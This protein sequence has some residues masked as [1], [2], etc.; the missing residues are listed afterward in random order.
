MPY[1]HRRRRSNEQARSPRSLHHVTPRGAGIDVDAV[2]PRVCVVGVG[3]VGE[4]L[5]REFGKVFPS[6]GFDISPKRIDELRPL[7]KGLP[8]T[9][10]TSDESALSTATHFLISVPT[11]L[12]QDRT[13]DLSHLLSAVRVVL[14][15]ARP[16]CVIVIESS[17]SVGTTRHIFAPYKNVFHCGMSPE[18]VDPGRVAPT[19][20]EI[21]KIVS[22]LTPKALD[23]IKALYGRVF[24]TVVPVSKPEVAEMTKLFENC[25]RMVNIAYVNEM[26]DAARSH[27]IDPE[28]MIAAAAS[29]PYG[30]T[31]FHPG[32]GV[33]GHCIPVNPFY[34]FANNRNLP[35][36]EKATTRMW[37][38]PAR[39]AKGFHRRAHSVGKGGAGAAPR[40]LVVGMG[41]K[42]GQ[43][44]LSCSPGVAF[45]EELRNLGC[46]RLSFY[47]PLVSGAM[48]DWIEKLGEG[49]WSQQYIDDN[50]DA[51]AICTRQTGV[52]FNVVENLQKARVQELK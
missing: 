45:A 34:L 19:A 46:A 27:G 42:P 8:S 14:A 52:D 50:F 24:D 31:P 7:F 38:R 25:Y 29:K 39:I 48:L 13:V 44:V 41:F 43:S 49:S 4:S 47:D 18:R 1:T 12:K 26:A 11:L 9:T 23:A 17:V 6:I 3:F 5:L 33:G 20:K 35:V 28:E 15:H 32:L 2:P 36:L 22:G 37:Q 21:P 10:L 16:G 40:I 51:V 30:F